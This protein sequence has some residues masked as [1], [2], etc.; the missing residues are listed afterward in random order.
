DGSES[1]LREWSARCGVDLLRLGNQA[2]AEEIKENPRPP[3]RLGAPALRAAGPLPPAGVGL[4]AGHSV[5]ELGAG[6]IAG[7]FSADAAV[8]LAGVRGREMAAGCALEATGMIAVL[9]RR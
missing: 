8:T 6:A 5:G 1:R 2:D 3:P 9:G 7:V 4:V